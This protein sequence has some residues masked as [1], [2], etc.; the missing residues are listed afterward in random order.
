MGCSRVFS[1]PRVEIVEVSSLG[2]AADTPA[3]VETVETV[4]ACAH[5]EAGLTAAP[6]ETVEIVEVSA[7]V[8]AGGA[9]AQPPAEVVDDAVG[10]PAAGSARV[11]PPGEF[12]EDG[13]VSPLRGGWGLYQSGTGAFTGRRWRVQSAEGRK[14]RRACS[15]AVASVRAGGVALGLEL[16]FESE[17]EL[18]SEF[19][20][21]K[22]SG[23]EDSDEWRCGF[24]FGW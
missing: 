9:C 1:S 7:L 3:P 19:M 6:V 22:L 17:L 18:E 21:E 11:P 4:E 15:S 13:E 12:G 5:A 8:A 10:S 14:A 16:E 23:L 20:V 2:M 24:I